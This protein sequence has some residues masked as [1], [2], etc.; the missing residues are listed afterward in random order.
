MVI[1]RITSVIYFLFFLNTCF[2]QNSFF[3]EIHLMDYKRNFQLKND[4]NNRIENSFMIRSAST[5]Q[6]IQNKFNTK[7]KNVIKSL[8]VGYDFQNNSLLPQGFN[9]GIMFRQEVGKSDIV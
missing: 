8:M 1:K 2:S 7:S 9:D 4:S 5:F 3:D 6:N